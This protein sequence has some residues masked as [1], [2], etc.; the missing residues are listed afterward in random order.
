[1]SASSHLGLFFTRLVP[2]QNS[3]LPNFLLQS[4]SFQMW[5]Q[6]RFARIR[7]VFSRVAHCNPALTPE[8]LPQYRGDH[9]WLAFSPIETTSSWQAGA[10]RT[11]SFGCPPTQQFL[12]FGQH[13]WYAHTGT[14]QIE[15]KPSLFKHFVSIVTID[16]S[17]S[18]MTYSRYNHSSAD[19]HSADFSS[20]LVQ[21]CTIFVTGQNYGVASQPT[22]VSCL[23]IF[24]KSILSKNDWARK[25]CSHTRYDDWS[26]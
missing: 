20:V 5:S 13:D 25:S 8:L 2:I 15:R 4:C 26:P 18:S 10:G 1:M 7:S 22:P 17:L 21:C 24:T 3:F 19:A 23:P 9:I 16:I 11:S 6:F 12:I 14:E